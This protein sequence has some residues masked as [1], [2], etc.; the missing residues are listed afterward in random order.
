MGREAMEGRSCKAEGRRAEKAEVSLIA[1]VSL[2]AKAKGFSTQKVIDIEAKHRSA[3]N[4]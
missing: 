3:Q 4:N 2:G 1:V